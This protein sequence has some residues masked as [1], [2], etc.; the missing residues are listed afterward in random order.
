MSIAIL[1]QQISY[2]HLARYRACAKEFNRF[3]VVSAMNDA[4]FREFLSPDVDGV[5]TMRLFEGRSAYMSAVLSGKMRSRMR[6]LLDGLRPKVVAVAG[7]SFPESASAVLWARE[8]GAR[9]VMMSESQE[10]DGARSHPR[11]IMKSRIVRS[12]DAALV[13][14]RRHGDYIARLGMPSERVFC[15][16]DAVDNSHFADG[17]DNARVDRVL[18]QRRMGLPDRFVLASARFI[19]KKNLEGLVAAFGRAVAAANVPHAL[20]ILGDG[21]GRAALQAAIA[22]LGL[23]HRVLLPGFKDYDSL[24]VFYGLA[25]AFVHVSLAEQWG[26]VIN[27]AAAAGLPLI[28]SRPCG[29]AP[30]LL[31]E[32]RNGYLV[33]PTDI[34]NMARTLIAAMAATKEARE[35][36]GAASRKI[37]SDWGPE[38]FGEGLRNAADAALATPARRLAPWDSLLLRTLSQRYISTVS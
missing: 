6:S 38:R 17:A 32:G 37:V 27:E 25:D 33:D 31:V 2:Y 29:A 14:G 3:A 16:Y 23:E 9:I 36:M 22:T 20:V 8:N 30:E 11:E 4:D 15:G 10:E 35:A 5:E 21:P 7:W 13:G 12:S 1:T 18:W 24:P 28:V 26:L 19:P 34:D